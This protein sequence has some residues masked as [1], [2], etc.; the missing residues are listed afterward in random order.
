M[1]RLDRAARLSRQDVALL[2]TAW[3]LVARARL[4]LW[5]LPWD[6]IIADPD[7]PPVDGLSH[8]NAERRAWAVRVASRLVPRATCLTQALALCGWLQREG[9]GSI[10]Q[11]G[12]ANENGRFSA[13]AWVE[14]GGIPL[15]TTRREADRYARCLTLPRAHA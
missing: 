3:M 1:T 11:I 13:H 8:C 5:L 14:Y 7:V 12:V 15:L 4:A 2:A 9:C 10:V 6:R